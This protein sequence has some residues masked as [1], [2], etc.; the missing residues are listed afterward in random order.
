M[1][2]KEKAKELIEIFHSKCNITIAGTYTIFKKLA[3]ALAL[4]A[5]EEVLKVAKATDSYMPS[6]V[7]QE[8]PDQL[9][10]EEYWL[11]V[12]KE[13]EA[14]DNLSTLTKQ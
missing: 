9:G 6:W 10:W 5:V 4:I 11:E 1:K 12:K 2:P 3:P 13:I 14:C 7:R 8:Y